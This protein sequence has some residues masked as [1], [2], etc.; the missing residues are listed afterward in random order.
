MSDPKKG[1]ASR[2]ELHAF[3]VN[4]FVLNGTPSVQPTD[5][6]NCKFA[7]NR[8]LAGFFGQ[9]CRANSHRPFKRCISEDIGYATAE[10][11]AEQ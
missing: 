7:K 2:T 6:F 3:S 10:L 5:A 9:C 4:V 8:Y 1:S 11:R